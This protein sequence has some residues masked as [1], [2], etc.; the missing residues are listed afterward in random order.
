MIYAAIVA[1][2]TGSRMGADIPKQ[3]LEIGGKPIIIR[4]IDRFLNNKHI[5]QVYI[6]VHTDWTDKLA[7]M[8]RA[9]M[10]DMSR[11]KIIS[12]G[13]DR[14][15]TVFRI[16]SSISSEYGVGDDDIILTHDGVRPFVSQSIINENIAIMQRYDGVTT[17]L[18]ST[19]TMLYSSDG[20][21]IEK[22]PERA[23]MFRAQ[24]PQTFRLGKLIAAYRSLD[25]EQRSL[26]TDTSSV[27][28]LAGLNVGLVHGDELNIKITTPFDLVMAET[29]LKYL[30][31]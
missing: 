19:D 5:D 30:D 4:T 14:N 23:K 7:E 6:G 11:I 25:N 22:V 3:F 12:G 15:D 27:F 20:N 21:C 24:T 1:G 8:C 10:L 18:P 9:N 28:T 16:I 17:S 29:I 13:T 2:G 31:K 26:L